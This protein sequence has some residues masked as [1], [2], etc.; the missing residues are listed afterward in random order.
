M[1][2]ISKNPQKFFAF[3]FLAS[4]FF[5]V[6]FIFGSP[7]L[8]QYGE[9]QLTNINVP[10]IELIRSIINIINYVLGFLALI[11]IIIVLYAG[12]L[13]MTAGGDSKK[14]DKAKK[15]RDFSAW[16]TDYG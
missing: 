9:E 3:A 2:K 10:K 11:A 16:Q 1:L 5:A 13:W 6:F 8:A 12:F 14:V 15:Y 7:A 4:I